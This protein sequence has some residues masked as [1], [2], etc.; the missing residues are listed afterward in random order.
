M[1]RTEEFDDPARSTGDTYEWTTLRTSP[2]DRVA[3]PTTIEGKLNRV[4]VAL[5]MCSHVSAVNLD[6]SSRD[7]SES[8]GGKRPPGGV[9]RKEDR[10]DEK[11]GA[12]TERLLRSADHYRRRLDRAHS[13]KAL[14]ATLTEAEASLEAWRKQPPPG[15]EPEFGTSQWKRWIGE[16]TEGYGA[17]ANRFGCSR[18]YIQQIKK[19]YRM[20]AA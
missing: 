2:R 18:S 1:S 15:I 11:A 17:L 9:D 20:E 16:S 6:P 12:N 5:E 3:S 8:I 14:A 13:Q 19:L 4:L 7:A 10:Q